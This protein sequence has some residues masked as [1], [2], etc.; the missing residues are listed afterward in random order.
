MDEE[1]LFNEQDV[2]APD[3]PHSNPEKAS[4]DTDPDL[5]NDGPLPTSSAQAPK[6]PEPEP[7]SARRDLLKQSLET[8][9]ELAKT[10]NLF[11][12]IFDR[13]LDS[14]NWGSE[15]DFIRKARENYQSDP[16]QGASMLVGKARDDLAKLMD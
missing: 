5:T 11:Q 9:A 13:E 15:D 16:F 4:E 8:K 2:I 12:K 6:I 1:N 10:R 3:Q 7:N 14:A